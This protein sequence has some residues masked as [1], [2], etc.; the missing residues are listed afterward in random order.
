MEY[1]KTLKNRNGLATECTFTI[2]YSLL[3]TPENNT[4]PLLGYN[5]KLYFTPL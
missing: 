2:V 5:Y 4:E 3:Q 1:K